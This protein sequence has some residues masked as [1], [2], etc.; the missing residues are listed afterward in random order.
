MGRIIMYRPKP[1][2]WKGLKMSRKTKR[3]WYSAYFQDGNILDFC[4]NNIEDAKV[5]AKI[6]AKENF[7]NSKLRI[8]QPRPVRRK[9]PVS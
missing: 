8:V 4:A 9:R 5:K 6:Y 7:P 3:I 2:F 1:P